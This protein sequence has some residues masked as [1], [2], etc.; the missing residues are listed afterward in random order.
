MLFPIYPVGELVYCRLHGETPFRES[1]NAQRC[2]TI[3]FSVRTKF[4][5]GPQEILRGSIAD[6][7][8]N[9][10]NSNRLERYTGNGM[11]PFKIIAV[12]P[13][14]SK[15]TGDRD[16]TVRLPHICFARIRI[17][18]TKR[19]FNTISGAGRL[20]SISK[21][22]KGSWESIKRKFGLRIVWNHSPVL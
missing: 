1:P 5:Q 12:A 11:H 7:G 17:C 2:K 14:R 15:V 19:F 6:S 9:S 18:R 4:R 22:K 21:M 10:T 13:V 3:R 16:V 8:R 20:N